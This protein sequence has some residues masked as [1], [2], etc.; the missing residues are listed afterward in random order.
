[1]SRS[2]ELSLELDNNASNNLGSPPLE[3]GKVSNPSAYIMWNTQVLYNPMLHTWHRDIT[4]GR[5]SCGR[6]GLNLSFSLFSKVFK[7]FSEI[8]KVKKGF[9]KTQHYFCIHPW[10]YPLMSHLM[11]LITGIVTSPGHNWPNMLMGGHIIKNVT[12]GTTAMMGG[13]GIASTLWTK[14]NNFPSGPHAR[15]TYWR[16]S[17]E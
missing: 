5:C 9:N 10:R 6:V 3:Q 4:A 2:L 15:R 7:E 1:M 8:N 12:V 13:R 17:V 11:N 16:Q 14:W